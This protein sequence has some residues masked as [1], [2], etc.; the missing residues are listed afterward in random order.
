[1]HY[2]VLTLTERSVSSLHAV[3]VSHT[4]IH[5]Y[6]SDSRNEDCCCRVAGGCIHAEVKSSRSAIGTTSPKHLLELCESTDQTS[7]RS[8]TRR[9]L[10]PGFRYLSRR[11]QLKYEIWNQLLP[12]SR[13]MQWNG[14]KGDMIVESYQARR[15]PPTRQHR[16]NQM[17]LHIS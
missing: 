12:F 11:K 9:C 7:Q 5:I 3:C 14:V 16:M 17:D 1:M 4:I 8:T 6:E 10:Y 15:T 2:R 13:P